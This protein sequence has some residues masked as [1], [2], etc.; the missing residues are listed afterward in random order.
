MSV[1]CLIWHAAT[2][3]ILSTERKFYF[4][5][6]RFLWRQTTPESG[7]TIYEICHCLWNTR[8]MSTA[9]AKSKQASGDE[10]A[11]QLNFGLEGGNPNIRNLQFGSWI[12][13][14]HSAWCLFT[15]SSYPWS[16]KAWKNCNRGMFLLLFLQSRY[17]VRRGFRKPHS[18]QSFLSPGDKPS[19]CGKIVVIEKQ[20]YGLKMICFFFFVFSHD[21]TYIVSGSEDKYVYIWSTYHDLSKF[22][23][24]RRDRND[25][26]EGVKG[27]ASPPPH[28]HTSDRDA[29]VLMC[30]LRII[31]SHLV[32]WKEKQPLKKILELII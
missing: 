17:C 22:T 30:L 11:L 31:W 3:L 1:F 14:V 12:D 26:W 25:F 19:L 27:K 32:W 7:C 28:T 23:S 2:L 5:I 18:A 16:L 15:S 20:E 4:P 29:V 24:V 6:A 21:F 10:K 9:A 8:V 13:T